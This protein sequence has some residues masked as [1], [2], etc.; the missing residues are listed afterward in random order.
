MLKFLISCL[1]SRWK[2]IKGGRLG[3]A[4][5]RIIGT[6]EKRKN[7]EFSLQILRNGVEFPKIL[8]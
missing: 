8:I 2:V 6:H 4:G 7:P 3:R 1:W 5:L